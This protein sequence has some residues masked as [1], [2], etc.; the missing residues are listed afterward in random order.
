[1]TFRENG[2]LKGYRYLLEWFGNYAAG[3]ECLEC[4]I[5]GNRDD[6]DIEFFAEDGKQFFEVTE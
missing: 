6:R 1:M 3:R 4:T 2:L 5:D